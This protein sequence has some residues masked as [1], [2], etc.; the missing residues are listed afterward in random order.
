VGERGASPVGVIAAFLFVCT[1]PLVAVVATGMTHEQPGADHSRTAAGELGLA[2]APTTDPEP[3]GTGT[4]DIPPGTGTAEIP[5]GTGTADIRPGESPDT[6]TGG[7]PPTLPDSTAPAS[8]ATTAPPTTSRR[9]PTPAEQ[10][11][12]M[13]N[14]AR[15][16]APEKCA[17]VKVEIHLT[18]AA[19]SHSD[20]MAARN[21]FSH[22]TPEGIG[23]AD[24]VIAAG[25]PRP[26]GE[27]IAKGQRSA[28][29]VMTD[30]LASPGHRANILNCA[31]TV[32]GVGVNDTAWTWT[33][34]FGY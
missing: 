33:Q 12:D 30:W 2:A 5:P 27:N 9:V 17:A 34:D 20:D 8:T 22:D 26:G 25:Y 24:R 3:P 1:A 28:E 29:Q 21:Y 14:A 31:F 7:A 16:G 10:V 11:V 19:Q 32:I 23:F 6:T 4:A 15:A 18:A 13:V